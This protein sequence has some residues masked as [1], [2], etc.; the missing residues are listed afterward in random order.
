VNLPSLS[1]NA[2]VIL[3]LTVSL[4][5][6]ALL[7]SRV[8][9]GRSVPLIRDA[10][11]GLLL[12]LIGLYTADRLLMALKWHQLL[13]VLDPRLSRLG[14]VRVYYESSFVGFAMPLGGLG[15]DIVR[16]VRLQRLGVMPHVTLVSMVME[17]FIGIVA[18]LGFVAVG[19]VVFAFIVPSRT[20][21][22]VALL[23]AAGALTTTLAAA[24]AVF[25]PRL[26]RAV[27]EL[28]L[29]SRRIA[30]ALGKHLEAARAYA[31]R[32]SLLV[33]NLGLSAIEQTTALWALWLGSRALD[34]P[35]PLSVCLAVASMTVVIQRLPVS[36]AGLGLREGSAA[37]LLVALGYD[38]SEALVL[39]MMLFVIFLVAL[40]PGAVIFRR[41]L[42]LADAAAPARPAAAAGVPQDRTA[43]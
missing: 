25:H 14:A 38:Y 9:W 35:L 15:P 42:R 2:R 10:H 32:R 5:L 21:S 33:T 19:L 20:L 4:G 23:A 40:S 24:A 8:D 16:Y 11:P 7:L 36:Y 37:A 17:R 34:T 3:Q 6:L 29:R 43:E 18:T 26:G 31:S 13:R 1:R 12:L 28:L 41:G 30:A 39:L 27:R 22:E